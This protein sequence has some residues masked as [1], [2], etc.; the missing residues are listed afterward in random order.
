MQKLSYQIVYA[1]MISQLDWLYESFWRAEQDYI[2]LYSGL[3]SGANGG[4]TLEG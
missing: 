4:P 2:F 1:S 3:S